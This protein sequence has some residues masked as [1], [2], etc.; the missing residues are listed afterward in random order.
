M[1]GVQFMFMGVWKLLLR[2]LS[3]LVGHWVPRASPKG[4]FSGFKVY[5]LGM[6]C[7]EDLKT[8]ATQ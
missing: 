1:T 7:T 8:P 3:E 4:F 5:G 2:V 6:G